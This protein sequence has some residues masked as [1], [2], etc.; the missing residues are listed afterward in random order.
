MQKVLWAVLA[1]L[2]LVSCGSP[3][4]AEPEKPLELTVDN[5]EGKWVLEDDSS[6]WY[7]FKV[8]KTFTSNEVDASQNGTLKIV[9]DKVILSRTVHGV[10]GQYATLECKVYRTYLII[11][12]KKFNKN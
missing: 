2:L 8:D 4:K 7:D 5:L 9:N 6:V 1:V 11:N 3:V 12:E 10:T